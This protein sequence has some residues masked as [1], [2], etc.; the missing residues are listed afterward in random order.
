METKKRIA[1]IG[2]GISGIAS[3]YF[4]NKK[5]YRVEILE[6]DSKIGGRAGSIQFHDKPI[7]IGGKNIGR[8]YTEFRKFVNEMGNHELE[9][10][11]INSSTVQ[12]G[13]LFTID[14]QKKWESIITLIQL[15]GIFNFYKFAKLAWAVRKDNRNGFLDGPYFSKLASKY[16]HQ[17]I[18]S[19]FTPRFNNSFLRPIVIRMNGS[20]P[21]NYYLGNFGSNVRMVLDKYDQFKNSMSHL[22]NDVKKM[23]PIHLNTEVKEITNLITKNKVIWK[24]VSAHGKHTPEQRSG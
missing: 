16:D 17:P 4:L 7:D 15:I 3:A 14:S 20:E 8:R 6:S 22:F 2:G 11:G 23:F 5:G 24:K 19:Y 1:V 18:T 9:F 12:N 13:K 10:F 21:E